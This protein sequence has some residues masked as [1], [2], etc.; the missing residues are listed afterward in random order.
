M[1]FWRSDESPLRSLVVPLRELLSFLDDDPSVVF[2]VVSRF[3]NSISSP[4]LSSPAPTLPCGVLLLDD[5]FDR[6][7]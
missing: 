6:P 4:I 5:D 3:S 1:S 2:P 7:P